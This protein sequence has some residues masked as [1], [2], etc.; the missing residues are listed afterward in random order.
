M[1][2]DYGVK[3]HVE[4]DLWTNHDLDDVWPIQP[5]EGEDGVI[6]IERT[7][8]D[9]IAL[10]LRHINDTCATFSAYITKE[11]AF[12]LGYALIREALS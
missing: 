11:R 4:T 1:T 8:E 6:D 12:K 10:H 7:D 3:G 5:F 2:F 9:E